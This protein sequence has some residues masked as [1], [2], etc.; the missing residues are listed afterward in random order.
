MLRPERSF[1]IDPT[2]QHHNG[3]MLRRGVGLKGGIPSLQNCD[4]CTAWNRSGDKNVSAT[5]DANRRRIHLTRRG[6]TG[7]SERNSVSI[8]SPKSKKVDTEGTSTAYRSRREGERLPSGTPLPMTFTQFS[9]HPEGGGT[10][11]SGGSCERRMSLLASE[12]RG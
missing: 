10:K 5:E 3:I 4:Q 9:I 1:G 7:K 12:I 2:G 11:R 8:V 6:E